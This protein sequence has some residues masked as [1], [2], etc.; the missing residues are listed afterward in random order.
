M[1]QKNSINHNEKICNRCGICCHPSFQIGIRKII[2]EQIHCKFLKKEQNGKTYC[3]VYD[4]RFDKAPWCLT[5]KQAI[6]QQ[7]LAHNCPYVKNINGFNGKFTLSSK[8]LKNYYPEIEK[9]I[10]KYGIPSWCSIADAVKFFKK[11]IKWKLERDRYMFE[12]I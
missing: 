3:S 11:P 2:I 8:I 5:L 4:S 12:I 7:M 6:R 9:H 10:L 1:I